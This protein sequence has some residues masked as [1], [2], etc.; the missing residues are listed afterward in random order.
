MVAVVQDIQIYLPLTGLIDIEAEKAKLSKQ[1]EKLEQELAGI[2]N[3]LKNE[4]FISNAK[5]EVIE[6]EKEKEAEIATKLN[7]VLEVMNDLN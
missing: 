4:K 1:K 3:K 6:K 2:Q 5:P 7:T